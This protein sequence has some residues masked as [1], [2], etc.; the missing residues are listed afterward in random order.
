MD[1]EDGRVVRALVDP[2]GGAIETRMPGTGRGNLIGTALETFLR[3]LAAFPTTV[4]ANPT[5]YRHR[6]KN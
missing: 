5:T 6:H 3:A 1:G 2:V 4:L